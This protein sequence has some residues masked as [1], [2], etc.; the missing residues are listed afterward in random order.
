MVPALAQNPAAAPAGEPELV[1]RS[2][3]SRV[4]V[5]R[6]GGPVRRRVFALRPGEERHL[7]PTRRAKLSRK[8]ASAVVRLLGELP[9]PADAPMHV[10]R[11]LVR[12]AFPVHPK[13]DWR[14]LEV[15]EQLL[16]A[17]A[18]WP[19]LHP[20][21][22]LTAPAMAGELGVPVEEVAAAVA[23]VRRYGV[24]PGEWADGAG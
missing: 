1:I 21:V 22:P 7:A 13:A 2:V 24:L 4:F 14:W 12:A 18:F 11:R 8:R 15:T 9:T 3:W 23:A 16:Y 20:G 19:T 5:T 17:A 10:V 6:R